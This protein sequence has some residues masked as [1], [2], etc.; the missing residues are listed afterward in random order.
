MDSVSWDERYHATDRLWSVEPNV[1]VEDRLSGRAPGIGLDLASGEGRNAIW[2]AAQGWTMTAV[3][4]SPVAVERGRAHSDRV[5]FVVADVTTW[6]PGRLFDLVL[7]AYLQ[8]PESEFRPLVARASSW[9]GPGGELFMVGHDRSNLEHGHGGP[10]SLQLLWDVDEILGWV[11]GLEIL[12]AG[13]V[14][15]EV[16]DEGRR[17]VALD[18]LLRLRNV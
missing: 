16:D 2:L 4:F 3:D 5:E 8:L 14:E 12:E 6:T 18:A 15:R 11:D 7:I 9:L 1:F 13:V 17:A 10:Q